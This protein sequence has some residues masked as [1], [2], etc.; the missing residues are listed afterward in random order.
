MCST[1]TFFVKADVLAFFSR[2]TPPEEP[3][4]IKEKEKQLKRQFPQKPFENETHTN[5]I[6][7]ATT[8]LANI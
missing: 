1:V 4:H 7:A 8:I 2:H 6:H 3:Y 5:G